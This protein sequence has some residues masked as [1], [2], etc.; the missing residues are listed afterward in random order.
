MEQF[1]S[2]EVSPEVKEAAARGVLPVPTEELIEILVLLADDP[3]PGLAEKAR[4]SISTFP[5]DILKP[6]A[7]SIFTSG[8]TLDF[9]SRPPFRSTEFLELVILNTS[10]PDGAIAR[11]ADQVEAFLIE[12][13]IINLMR[14]LR[15]PEILEAL[16]RN[17]HNTPN[18]RRRLGEIREEFFEKRNTF[19]PVPPFVFH[20]GVPEALPELPVAGAEEFEIH[21]KVTE[22]TPEAVAQAVG[23]L[24]QQDGEEVPAERLTTLQK[25]AGMTVSERVQLAMKGTRDE[26]LILIRDAN[27][28]VARAV[29]Q[30]PKIS[31]NEVEWIAQMRNVNEEVLRIIGISRAWVKQYPIVHNLVRNARAPVSVTLN[32]VNR[33]LT[34]DL[35]MLAR[36][37]NIPEVIRRTA[38]RTVQVREQG[39]SG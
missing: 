19:V 14:V 13:I 28:V 39:R 12:A 37:K 24:M 22:E 31:G 5:D 29:L 38:Q 34:R 6:L 23:R 11:L 35:K 27:K 21:P 36:N 4:H 32:L 26:R 18:T 20:E 30:S 25:I 8:S 17:P 10:T 33:V 16:E 3:N 15:C 2:G 7:Q 1:K 9:F